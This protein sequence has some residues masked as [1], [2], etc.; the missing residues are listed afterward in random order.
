MAIGTGV[1]S[2]VLIKII[3]APLL[4]GA[5]A[6]ALTFLFMWPRSRRE[7]YVRLT[8]AIAM[9]GI[10]GPFLVVM[11]HSWWP[12]LFASAGYVVAMFGVD[13]SMGILY[14]AAPLM[15]LA[16]LPA[17]WLLGGLVRW[18]DKRKD[19]DLAEIAHDAA[20]MVKD[21]RGTL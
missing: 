20:E 12:A 11:L 5:A 3:G 8:C 1:A 19:K 9:S 6:S 16:G 10:L 14:V 13:P 18:L 4:A 15:V 21:M 17:W 7:A 2:G